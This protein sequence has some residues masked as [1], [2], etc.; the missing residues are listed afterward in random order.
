M[1]KI[2]GAAQK[3]LRIASYCFDRF[4]LSDKI[5]H[6]A[7]RRVKVRVLVDP[8]QLSDRRKMQDVMRTL[9]EWG[10]KVFK[11]KAPTAGVRQ[12][13]G[14][15]HIKGISADGAELLS[16]SA[17]HT[18]AAV[19]R[20]CEVAVVIKDSAVVRKFDVRFDYLC[21]HQAEEVVFPKTEEER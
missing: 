8:H 10:V 11:W 1:L 7:L 4:D 21:R 13:D 17:N 16:G 12:Y 20:N 2:V 5:V 18:Q 6:A 3:T 14:C 9:A 15:M 19:E